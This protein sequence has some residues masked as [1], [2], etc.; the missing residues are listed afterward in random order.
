MTGGGQEQPG[1]TS[2]PLLPCGDGGVPAPA[3]SLG[4]GRTDSS[5]RHH[6]EGSGPAPSVP[7]APPVPDWGEGRANAATT[8][9]CVCVCGVGCPALLLAV[10]RPSLSSSV[11]TSTYLPPHMGIYISMTIVYA[12][13]RG[14]V[15]PVMIKTPWAGGR[16]MLL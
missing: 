8:G 3:E 6:G 2:H 14:C 13:R 15:P 11:H 4:A 9:V 5:R 16:V 7:A 10:L 1:T 12:H